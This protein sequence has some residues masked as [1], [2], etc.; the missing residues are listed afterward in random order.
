MDIVYEDISTRQS[1]EEIIYDGIVEVKFTKR[2]GT[3]RIMNCT[4]NK[5]VVPPATKDPLSQQKVRKL[6]ENVMVVWD[7]DKN[8][9]RSFRL[10]QIK[11]FYQKEKI[12]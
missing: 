1:I 4:L 12:E 5:N 6:N 11:T 8:D 3:E 9:W 2:D 10:D 7:V